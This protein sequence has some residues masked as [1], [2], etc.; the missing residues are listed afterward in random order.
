MV[1]CLQLMRQKIVM[2]V[3]LYSQKLWLGI[4]FGCLVVDLCKYQIKIQ[5]YFCDGNMGPKLANLIPANLSSY[6]V[7]IIILNLV[8]Q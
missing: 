7:I 5:Q 1:F 4:K 8:L 2:I 6:T 3:L